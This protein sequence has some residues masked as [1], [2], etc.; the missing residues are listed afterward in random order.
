MDIYNYHPDTNAYLGQSTARPNPLEPDAWL[1]PAYATT[2]APPSAGES[3]TAVYANG[4]WS[5]VPDWRGHKYWLADGSEHTIT[6]LGDEPPAGALDE[7][8]P[9]TL[10]EQKAALVAE[11][12]ALAEQHDLVAQRS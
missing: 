3:Q 11:T 12:R 2:D 9:P 1:I 7:P 5:L 8:P 10:V 4:S 6:T